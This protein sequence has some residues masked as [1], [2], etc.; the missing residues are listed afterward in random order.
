LERD[1]TVEEINNALKK[2][3]KHSMHGIIEY[4]EEP[5][6]SSDFLNN[7]HSAIVDALSTMVVDK[8]KAKLLAWYD[9]EW[10]Y[11]C[12][13]IDLV[14]YVSQTLPKGQATY[15]KLKAIG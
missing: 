9:N 3:A 7:N 5:L 15:Q 11:S 14:Q 12:R 8:R 2:A 1:I 4:C 10:G 13:V 6:V